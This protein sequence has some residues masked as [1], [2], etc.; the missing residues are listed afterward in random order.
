VVVVDHVPVVHDEPPGA[1]DPDVDAARD[2]GLR[3]PG[4]EAG[5]V[6]AVGDAVVLP[7]EVVVPLA[8]EPAVDLEVV[9]GR[10]PPLPGLD[11]EHLLAARGEVDLEHEL[12]GRLVPVDVDQL[13]EDGLAPIVGHHHLV[14][15]ESGRPAPQLRE[16]EGDR[17]GRSPCGE[18]VRHLDPH[19]AVRGPCPRRAEQQTQTDDD[20]VP[21]HHHGASAVSAPRG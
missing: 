13:G 11:G 18:W 7:G 5:P 17:L 9:P 15:R 2:E 10:R 19:A 14:R 4:L 16:V 6:G 3:G 1:L 12:V 21:L 20:R 8:H